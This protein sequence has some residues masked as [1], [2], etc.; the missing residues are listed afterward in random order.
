MIKKL[1]ITSKPQLLPKALKQFI[2]ETAAIDTP[3]SI[4]NR[5]LSFALYYFAMMT[6]MTATILGLTGPQV[7]LLSMF[8]HAFFFI[9]LGVGVLFCMGKL[10]VYGAFTVMLP[11]THFFTSVEMIYSSLHPSEYYMMLLIGNMFILAVNHLFALITFRRNMSYGLGIGG[12]AVYLYCLYLTKDSSLA[13]FCLTYLVSFIALM[14]LGHLMHSDMIETKE[15]NAALKEELEDDAVLLALFKTER[16][17]IRAFAQLAKD[18]HSPVDAEKLLNLLDN[19]TQ[20]NILRNVESII[21]AKQVR[22]S[23][24]EE[25]LPMLTHSEIEIARLVLLGKTLKEVSKMLNKT[26]TNVTVQ[27][28][29]IRKKLGLETSDNLREALRRKV[30]TYNQQNEN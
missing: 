12:S 28:T 11:C 3:T 8:N 26:E 25:A 23:R 9:L 16:K 6:G 2:K 30:E 4:R 1:H 19:D 5:N 18:A 13:N 20:S 7:H 17:N 29:N 24:I 27:R 14:V 15:K 21:Q 22:E 10:K